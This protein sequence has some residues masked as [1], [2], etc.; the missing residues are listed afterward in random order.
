M[1]PQDTHEPSVQLVNP[2]EKE[3]LAGRNQASDKSL[4]SLAIFVAHAQAVG[5]IEAPVYDLKK[6]Y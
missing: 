6:S 5:K 1:A 3:L 4:E 2:T